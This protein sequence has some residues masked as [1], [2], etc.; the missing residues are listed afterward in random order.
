M[1]V[2]GYNGCLDRVVVDHAQLS[3]LT[4]EEDGGSTPEACG[5]RSD[6]VAR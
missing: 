3:L 4:P 1:V 6:T 2:G 5:P